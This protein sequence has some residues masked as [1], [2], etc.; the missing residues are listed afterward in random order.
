MKDN[1]EIKKIAASIL[2][3]IFFGILCGLVVGCAASI[4]GKLIGWGS[5]AFSEYP[6]LLFCMIPAGLAIV[7]WQRLLKIK[8]VRGTNLVI[9]S[10]R[11][12]CRL[13]CK[14]APH[15]F[16][17]T[18]LTHLTGGSAGREGAAL[19]IGG[20]LGCTLGNLLRFKEE[21]CRRTIMCGMSAAFSA[22]FGTP[23]AATI[24]SMEIS[25]VG[26][27]YHSALAPCMFSALT[28]HL[29]AEK[30]FGLS[31]ADLTLAAVPEIDIRTILMVILLAICCSAVSALFCWVMH[32]TAHLEKQ[33]LKNDCLRI[34]VSAA[35][36][37]AATLAIGTRMYNGSGAAVIE[38]C[39][40]DP[41]FKIFPAAFLIK[42]VLTAVTL[43]GG[44]QG[45][46]IVPSLFTGAAFGNLFAQVCGLPSPLCS[47]LGA[48][49]VFCGVT[50]CPVTALMIAF[51]MFGFGAGTLFL[52]VVAVTYL[53]SGYFGIWSSQM[54]RFSKYDPGIIDRK[55]H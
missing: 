13:P 20:S 11:E 55:T 27:M 42:I 48:A 30:V 37:I 50:N 40:S 26:V 25:T 47:A 19:Q 36:V 38:Q 10:V 21:D 18:V 41:G 12:G 35:V 9:E 3:W 22:L 31:E 33:Y 45:G 24:M 8:E 4:F 17:G 16:V 5:N 46:E 32:K 49:A 51:E 6:W 28:A 1:S 15:I 2:K 54:I 52:L 23:L 34:V 53:F 39:I 44:F 29:V 14:M 7:G 43:G